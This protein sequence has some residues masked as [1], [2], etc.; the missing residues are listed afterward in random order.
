MPPTPLIANNRHDSAK[1]MLYTLDCI[2]LS[3]IRSS[4]ARCRTLEI[5][6]FDSRADLP[7]LSGQVAE[8]LPRH[9]ALVLHFGGFLAL[10]LQVF[11]VALQTFAELV[12]GVFERA[13]DFCRDTCGVRVSVVDG[14]ELRGELG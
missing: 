3:F 8:E 14:G 5:D 6:S 1:H 12:G 9:L 10:F 4:D 7:A 13:A 2:E 11:H